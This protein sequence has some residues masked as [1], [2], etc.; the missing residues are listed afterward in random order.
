MKLYVPLF[1]STDRCDALPDLTPL[2][3]A[4]VARQAEWR[5][6]SSLPRSGPWAGR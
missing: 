3:I 4:V 2:D 6:T 1:G 5:P